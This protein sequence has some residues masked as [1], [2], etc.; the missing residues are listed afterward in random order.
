MYTKALLVSTLLA[1]ATLVSAAPVPQSKRCI[2]ACQTKNLNTTNNTDTNTT[3]DTSNVNTNTNQAN[4]GNSNQT[5][6]S[7]GGN[8]FG[9]A[10]VGKVCRR[11]FVEAR[12]IN[13]A[14]HMYLVA[15][16][17]EHKPAAKHIGVAKPPPGMNF[18][19]NK[20][21]TNTATT[22]NVNSNNKTTKVDNTK[23]NNVNM[24]NN[25]GQINGSGV[26]CR[27]ELEEADMERRELDTGASVLAA[28]GGQSIARSLDEPANL[29]A[30]RDLGRLADVL[31]VRAAGHDM[32]DA[33]HYKRSV[34]LE[35]ATDSCDGI[36]RREAE[37]ILMVH[38]RDLG[39]LVEDME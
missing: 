4:N 3:T 2:G 18:N 36:A 14:Q 1:S 30:T 23:T 20:W 12:G 35:C 8:S 24:S 16:K 19:S 15:R 32:D 28:L 29:L 21:M 13:H 5:G 37:E 17:E 33:T 6:N 10:S 26:V 31:G 9:N 25:S 39:F 22:N 27:R 34:G 11:A 7:G 38:A